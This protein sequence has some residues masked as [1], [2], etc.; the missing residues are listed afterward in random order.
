MASDK[1][2]TI[3]DKNFEA[4]VLHSETPTLV[5]FW[6]TWCAPCRQIAPAVEA[7]ATEH[8]GKLKVGKLDVDNNPNVP[9]KYD[10]RSIPTLL[11]FHKGHVIGQMM[12][13][14]PKA[15]IDQFVKDHLAKAH[16]A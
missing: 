14:A 13:A 1:L 8:E 7:L 2:M 5:D 9:T 3:T 15:K 10:V 12:G 6:A 16:K 11:L 4:E